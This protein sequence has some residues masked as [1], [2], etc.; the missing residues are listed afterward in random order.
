MILSII[1]IGVCIVIVGGIIYAVYYRNK[2]RP[3][4][5]NNNK[6]TKYVNSLGKEHIDSLYNLFKSSP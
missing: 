1:L 3:N 2:Q 6:K 5:S 4:N